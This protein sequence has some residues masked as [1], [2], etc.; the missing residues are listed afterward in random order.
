MY[1]DMVRSN[2]AHIYLHEKQSLPLDSIEGMHIATNT[3]YEGRRLDITARCSKSPYPHSVSEPDY[4]DGKTRVFSF[5]ART[6]EVRTA[7]CSNTVAVARM[8]PLLR[9]ERLYR[10]LKFG[11][12]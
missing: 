7:K 4:G 8:S 10:R 5:K 12:P 2:F 11:T 9:Y 3:K 6:A 1:G